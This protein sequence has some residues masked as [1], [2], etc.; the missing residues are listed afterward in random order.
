VIGQILI[1]PKA[2]EESLNVVAALHAGKAVMLD[3]SDMDS[4]KARSLLD[5][6]SGANSVLNGDEEFIGHAA[7]LFTPKQN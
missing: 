1:K 3:L 6:V 4:E 2:F 7:Y 5:F